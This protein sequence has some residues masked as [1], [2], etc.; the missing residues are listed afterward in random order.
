MATRHLNAG[1]EKN[2]NPRLPLDKQLSNF[3]CPGQVVVYFYFYYDRQLA[4]ALAH[5]ASENKRFLAQRK[6]YLSQMTGR[7][8][9]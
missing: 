6:I 9:F 8:F 1:L 2:S 4:W 7:H 5:R 3:A